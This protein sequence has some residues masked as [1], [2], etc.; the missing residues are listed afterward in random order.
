MSRVPR[1]YIENAICYVTSRGDHE[2]VIFKEEGDYKMYMELLKRTKEQ[3]KFELFAF[4]LLPNHAHL[5]IEPDEENAISQ[6]MHGLGSNY[7]KYFNGK[8]KRSGHLFQE[9]YKMT[10]IEK[11]PNIANVT[12]YIHLNPKAIGITSEPK[13][14]QYSSYPSYLYYG[15][16]REILTVAP[17][18]SIEKEVR[19]VS[20][21]L[22]GRKYEDYVNGMASEVLQNL[23]KELSKKP[24]IGS[25]E[26]V[27]RVRSRI[28][29]EKLRSEAHRAGTGT[30]AGSNKKFIVISGIIFTVLALLTVYLYSRT[31]FFRGTLK[32]KDTELKKKMVK[33]KEDIKKDFDERYRAD[34]VSYE[35]TSKRLENEKAKTRELEEKLT[36]IQKKEDDLYGKGKK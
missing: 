20:G 10:L 12:A 22:N 32:N 31:I 27:Q 5:L 6:T 4:C 13:S 19:E 11:D 14:Y 9:R 26:F 3:F 18:V 36:E 30:S 8:Y 2:G 34:M 7:T 23:G 33:A 35:A 25:D 15:G 1:V 16:N 28:E 29:S 17:A 24:V 21:Y